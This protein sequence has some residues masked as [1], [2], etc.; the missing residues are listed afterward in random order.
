MDVNERLEQGQHSG[1]GPELNP[2]E[3]RRYLGTFRERVVAA[4]KASQ[5]DDANVKSRFQ[6]L[7]QS[8]P[9]ATVAIDQDVCGDGYLDYLTM[10]VSAG[11]PYTLLSN[12]AGT[13]ASKDPYA[14]VL[15]E[16]KAVNQQNIEL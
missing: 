4:V 3:K 14:V 6:E 15:A 12:Y 11:N 1:S 7:L 8:W 13:T 2:D 5:V 16:K 10:A 9:E